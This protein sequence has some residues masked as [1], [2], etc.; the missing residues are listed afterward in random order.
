MRLASWKTGPEAF[1]GWTPV[2]FAR[3]VNSDDQRRP[4]RLALDV[5]SCL[6][7][8]ASLEGPGPIYRSQ[9]LMTLSSEYD[10]VIHATVVRHT[11][12]IQEFL[13]P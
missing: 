4:S 11:W 3:L 6:C 5:D 8:T 10:I 2:G 1:G 12:F 7:L 9:R 13:G